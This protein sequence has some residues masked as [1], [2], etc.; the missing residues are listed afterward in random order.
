M[1]EVARYCTLNNI[2]WFAENP[3]RSWLWELDVW[4]EL[5]ELPGVEDQVMQMCMHGSDR[6]KK[7]RLR[8]N[9]RSLECMAVL[10][11]RS[12][13]HRPWR[14]A[15]ATKVYFHHAEEAEYPQL[16]CS[17]LARVAADEARRRG[18]PVEK[19]KQERILQRKQERFVQP[20]QERIVQSKQER[21]RTL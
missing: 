3:W 18:Y 11:D 12:H 10:C 4:R 8:S 1:A 20:K 19:P 21:I 9:M 13:E 5:L 6:D 17:R 15:R 2:L 14:T 7:S 16:F